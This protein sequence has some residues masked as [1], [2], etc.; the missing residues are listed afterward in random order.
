MAVPHTTVLSLLGKEV[1]F[2]VLLDDQFKSFF[3]DGIHVTGE[4]EEV[5]IAVNGNHQILVRGGFHYLSRI[6]L[7]I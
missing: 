5:I 4:V 1:S 3:P 2:S 6:D 7:K